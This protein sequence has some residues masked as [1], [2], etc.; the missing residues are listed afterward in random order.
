MAGTH[1]IR[2]LRAA[3]AAI[4]LSLGTAAQ[5][6]VYKWVEDDGRV[7][8]SNE[9]PR[10]PGK[11]RELSRIDDLDLVPTDERVGPAATPQPGRGG[12]SGATTTAPV[13]LIPREAP[14][15]PSPELTIVKPAEPVAQPPREPVTLLGREPVT[16]LP[17]DPAAPRVE[18]EPPPRVIPR[19]TH[20]G[21]V[22]D[23]CLVSPDPR[24]HERNKDR[25]HPYLGYS[26]AGGPVSQAVGA[27]SSAAAGGAVGGQVAAQASASPAK[28]GGH[29]LPPGS[30]QAAPINGTRVAR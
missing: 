16:L 25:Y 12:E 1:R 2:I 14:Q 23:P 22:Q 19:S 11:V 13:T 15:R 9:P 3:L 29:A 26:P 10:D 6:V 20:T 17:R 7:V 8:Y 4:A 27:S 28:R 30:P 24:C 18:V 5:A 21:A